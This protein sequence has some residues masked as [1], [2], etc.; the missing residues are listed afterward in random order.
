[1]DGLRSDMAGDTP[2]T[3]HYNAKLSMY[4]ISDP[5]NH[6]KSFDSLKL[7]SGIYKS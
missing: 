4:T 2:N 7:S 6:N 1:M 5:F 3:L